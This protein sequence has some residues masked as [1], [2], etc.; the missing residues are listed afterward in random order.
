MDPTQIPTYFLDGLNM[1][2]DDFIIPSPE[3]KVG[4][5]TEHLYKNHDHDKNEG[6]EDDDGVSDYSTPSHPHDLRHYVLRDP[7]THRAFNVKVEIPEQSNE[8]IEWFNT[9]DHIFE[10]QKVPK[11][12]KVKLVA[13][14]LRKHASFLWEN[15][16]KQ[17]DKEGRSKILTWIKMKKELTRKYLTKNFWQDVFLK[18]QNFRQKDLSIAEYTTVFDNLMLKGDL[19]EPEEQTIAYYLDGLNYEISNVLQLQPYWTF[20]DVCKL[21]FKVENQ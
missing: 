21:A 20:N 2:N 15:L 5:D 8:F 6:F 1:I 18:I 12:R 11:H 4:V 14:K 19:M 9:V 13:I 17:R 16:K 7:E 10:Y 3:A